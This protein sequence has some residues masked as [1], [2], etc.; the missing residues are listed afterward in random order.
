[1]KQQISTLITMLLFCVF[2]SAQTIETVP[3]NIIKKIADRN[4]QA[5]WGDVYPSEPIPYY[6]LDEE[7]IA[8]RFNYSIGVPFPT[9]E[10][11]LIDRKEFKEIG[12]KR[13]QWGAGKFGRLLIAA[14]PDLPV[15]IE[16][17]ACLSPEYAEAAKMERM[18]HKAFNGQAAEFIKVYYFDHFNTWY[19]YRSGEIVK[20]INLSP[21][22]GIIDHTK[23]EIKRQEAGY[24]IQPDDFSK[25]WQKYMDGFTP[26]TDAAKYIPYYLSM[27]Y[28]DWSYGCTPTAGAMLLAYWD[29]TSLFES[30]KYAGFV[31]YHYQREDDLEDETDYNVANL[32]LL[33]ALAMD[34]DTTSGSTMPHMMDNGYKHVCNTTMP[35]NFNIETHY[36]LHWTRTKE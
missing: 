9:N 30:W 18:L 27:P 29:I 32:Q 4:A 26:E 23:F 7:I 13:A 2:A 36:S 15:M 28:Y 22:G 5:D 8:W 10:Q 35:Y 33:L 34:T 14:R 19:K 1:M 21:T 25:D 24:F 16:S 17:S 31:Q 12:D 11:L 6:G 20:Y 3:F